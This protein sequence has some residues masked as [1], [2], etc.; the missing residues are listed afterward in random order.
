MKRRQF[1]EKASL[2]AAIALAPS[3]APAE[4]GN[5]V[6]SSL[7]HANRR[8]TLPDPKF[9]LAVHMNA[10]FKR[11]AD[12][13]L[14]EDRFVLAA[15]EGAK[16]YQIGAFGG[17]DLD[18]YRRNADLHGM[19]CASIAGTGQIGLSTG[20]TVTGYEKA[21]LNFF[22]K[23]VETAKILGAQNLVSFVGERSDTIP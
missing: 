9:T 22:S 16:A 7:S 1:I 20:L 8:N 11:Q 21:Y 14:V 2:S 4:S 10:N 15:K 12:S 6:S 18:E 5:G 17:L 19:R 23:A 13:M 3:L